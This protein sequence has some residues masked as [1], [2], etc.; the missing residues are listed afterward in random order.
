MTQDDISLACAIRHDFPIKKWQAIQLQDIWNR[1][2]DDKKPQTCFCDQ[3]ER[4]NFFNTFFEWFDL[5]LQQ[6][7]E[8]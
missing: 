2:H 5:T 6:L 4:N 1:N 8:Q 3:T 7:N